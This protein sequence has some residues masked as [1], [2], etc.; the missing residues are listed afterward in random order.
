MKIDNSFLI[1]RLQRPQGSA[2]VVLDTDAFNEIDDQ[3]ALSYL[4]LSEEKLRTEAVYAAPFYNYKSDSPAQGMEKSYQEIL[5]VMNLCGKD[6]MAFRG[7]DRYLPDEKTPVESDAARDLVKRAM[8]RTPDKP[9]Y[10]L[11]IGA[12]TNV[13]S[14]LLMEPEIAGRIVIVFLGG[15][16]HHWPAEPEFNLKQDVAAGRVVFG[17]GAPLVQLPCGGAV[18]RLATTEPELRHYIKGKSTL[19]DYLYDITCEEVLARGARGLNECWSR[20]IWDAS[21]VAWLLSEQFVLDSLVTAPIP[22]YDHGY[23]Y[24]PRRHLMKVAYYVNRDAIFADLF[25]KIANAG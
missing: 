6:K 23:V 14:A 11:A 4:L 21:T 16:A 2:D 1:S 20:V 19:G 13:A 25:K 9:L 8:A 10:V 12:I 15:H 18:D 24:D 7:S 5:N 17:S 3:Y 22:S